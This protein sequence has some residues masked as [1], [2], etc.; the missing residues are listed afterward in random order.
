MAKHGPMR[1]W[2]M[3][4]E[5]VPDPISITSLT[6]AT[7]T[8][9]ATTAEAHGYATG[10]YVTVAGATPA[11][12]NGKVKIT[13]TG[14]SAFTYQVVGALTTPAT[15]TITVVYVSDAQG[16]RKIGWENLTGVWGEQLPV[17]AMER[18]QAQ[19]LQAQL[20]YRFRVHVN[21]D[22]THQMRVV[23]TP[24]WPPGAVTH[25]L[26]IQGIAPFEDGRQ[27]AVLECAEIAP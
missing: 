24:Q 25:T 23:W 14:L 9:T 7:T 3:I 27:F 1:E 5:N 4:Q 11:G 16:G 2:L 17:R 20:D 8:A 13:V 19:A 6:R 22:L 18:L 15:G 26:E 12:Y 10:D 21:P